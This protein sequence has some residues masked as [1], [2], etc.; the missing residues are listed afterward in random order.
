MS[1]DARKKSRGRPAVDS[2]E[3]RARAERPLIEAIESWAQAQPDKPVRSEA[4]R[5]LIE[6]G[7]KA[8]TE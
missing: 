3:L 7:L 1:I 8:A 5:R 4:I 6:I 2:E